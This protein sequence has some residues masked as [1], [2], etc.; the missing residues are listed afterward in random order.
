MIIDYK[1]NL[2]SESTA[3]ELENFLKNSSWK[4]GYKSLNDAVARS[5]P[6]WSIQFAGKDNCCNKNYDCEY[7]LTGIIKEIWETIKPMYFQGH[8]LVRCYANAITQGIDQRLHTDDTVDGSKTFVLYV[9]K[10]WTVDWAGETIVWDREKRQIVG[11][12]LPKFNSCLVIPGNCWHGVR[13]VS[14]Y[15][16][17]LRMTLMFK[18]RPTEKLLA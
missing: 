16:D 6:H 2:L 3:E 9:N 17:T 12:Y 4:W 7:E 5:I 15:C 18:T 10:V 8:T 1:E 14:A 13:P 11:S